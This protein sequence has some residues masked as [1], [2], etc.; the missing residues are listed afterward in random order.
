[1]PPLPRPARPGATVRA[2]A[3]VLPGV[4]ATESQI[5][6]HGAAWAER[7]A[8]A[9]ASGEPL[10]VALGDS[11]AL[12][13][14]AA[15]PDGGYVAKVF[16]R[17]PGATP[18]RLVNLAVSGARVADLR[19]E[20]LPVLEA[21]R[22]RVRVIT[23]SIGSNDLVRAPHPLGLTAGLRAL[24]AE[25]AGDSPVVVATLPVAPVSVNGRVVNA[26]IRR[27]APARGLLVAD[28]QRRR[29]LG[30]PGMLA[31]DRFHPSERAYDEW[32]EAFIDALGW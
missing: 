25:L 31:A 9:I 17:R 6:R 26:M 24:F 21:L 1:M 5:E 12:A 10:L 19:R 23:V 4:R 16:A 18:L 7:S 28:L 14:G 15:E 2:L 30:G 20:Q 3:R 27:E 11:T 22:G 8:D 29:A 13:V 32:A